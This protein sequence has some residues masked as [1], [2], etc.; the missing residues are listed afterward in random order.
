[1]LDFSQFKQLKTL[2][3]LKSFTDARF[4]EIP[5]K[6]LYQIAPWTLFDSSTWR[7]TDN[8]IDI[9]YF[10]SKDSCDVVYCDP[11]DSF[12]KPIFNVVIISDEEELL[13]FTSKSVL[14]EYLHSLLHF[15]SD[16]AYLKLSNS[17]AEELVAKTR[18]NRIEFYDRKI[19][20]T[21]WDIA[22]LT[23]DL[24]DLEAS[25]AEL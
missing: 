21:K 11:T 24:K 2:S 6:Y 3:D 4:V 20:K 5:E 25:R 7:D 15:P 9:V 14:E 22:V 13:T 10:N 12:E 16:A 18:Q 19:S 8:H 23:S 17:I 1:M